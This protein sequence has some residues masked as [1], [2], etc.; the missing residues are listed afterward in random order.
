MRVILEKD[1]YKLPGSNRVARDKLLSAGVSVFSSRDDF[2]YTHAKYAVADGRNYVFSTG[3]YTKSTFSK[4]REFF[5]FGNHPES[6]KFLHSVFESDF[7]GSPFVGYIPDRFYLAPVDA[8]SKILSFVAR[9]KKSV[10]VFA[11]SVSDKEFINTLNEVASKGKTVRVCLLKNAS[12]ADLAR[13]GRG[14]S[15]VRS[16]RAQLHAKTVWID[17]RE[18]LVGSANFTRNS[19][20]NNREVGAVFGSEKVIRTYETTLF[21]DCKW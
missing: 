14:I 7:R 6:A 12:A 19:L 9:S 4:N 10:T 11:P 3:N 2:A 16:S 15:V 20:D 21:R 1:P 8:R 5:V 17:G 18:L 13:F